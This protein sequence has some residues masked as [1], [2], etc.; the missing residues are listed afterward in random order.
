ME[1]EILTSIQT[2][3]TTPVIS[4]TIIEIPKTKTKQ[5]STKGN[6]TMEYNLPVTEAINIKPAV[7]NLTAQVPTYVAPQAEPTYPT[8]QQQQQQPQWQLQ[9]Q[10]QQFAA[11]APL[12]P[13]AMNNQSN[14]QP[15][16]YGPSGYQLPQTQGPRTPSLGQCTR[17]IN[18]PPTSMVLTK[19]TTVDGADYSPAVE[20]RWP[21]EET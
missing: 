19:I 14:P 1:T 17:I 11:Y 16:P 8:Q 15:F 4:E 18:L 10:P 13:P 5:K 3:H 7:T 9:Q 2:D 21:T 20:R 12:I 6:N